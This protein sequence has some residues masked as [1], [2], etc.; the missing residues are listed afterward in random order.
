MVRIVK[1]KYKLSI[2]VPVYNTEKYV[3]K[4]IQSILNQTFKDFQ[5]IIINDGSTDDSE[6][7]IHKVIRKCR[8]NVIYKKIKNAGVAHARNIGLS[9]ATGDYI[10][11][12]DSDDYLDETMFE[13]LYKLA[14]EK[15]SEIVGCAYKKIFKFQEKE[16]HPKD[17]TC[18]G[19]SLKASKEIIFNSN[20]YTPVKIFKRSLI[21]DNEI[22][23]DEDLRIFED[24]VFCYKLFLLSNKICFIDECLYNYNC[25]NESS[26]TSV[27]SEKMFD[28]Y[29]ALERLILFYRERCGN[30]FDDVLE[31]ISAKHIS[32]RYA[33][34]PTSRKLKAKYVDQSYDFLKKNFKNY[35]KSKY[36]TGLSGFVKKHK[37]L[38]KLYLFI[39][40]K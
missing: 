23:F 1:N 32:L 30:K 10:A 25:K 14:I 17:V 28:I 38:I 12:V 8:S 35:K 7:V 39:K 6:K 24:L 37:L 11:F 29:P 21:V 13:K 20:P 18:F 40:K 19:K 15:N 34:K 36:Y 16:I 5:L 4:C 27:F 9:Y 3:G 33:E 31:Y 26:L 2:I 22:S